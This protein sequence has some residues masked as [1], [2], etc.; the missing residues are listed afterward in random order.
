MSID[1]FGTG[2]SS[3]SRLRLL[4]VDAIKIDRTFVVA[5]TA[6]EQALLEVIV[7]AAHA[8]GLTA[9]GEGVETEAQLRALTELG[10]DSAQGFLLSRPLDGDQLA[11]HRPLTLRAS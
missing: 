11:A 5:A 4:P 1:D 10:C 7:R 8:A 3:I 9:V 6:G 2:Y